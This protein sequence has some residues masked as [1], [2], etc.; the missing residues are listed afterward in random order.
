ME[1]E[2]PKFTLSTV[3]DNIAAHSMSAVLTE[4]QINPPLVFGPVIHHLTSLAAINTSNATV[5]SLI[6]GEFRDGLEASRSM[7]WVDVRDLS[8]AHVLALEKVA[9]AG[10]RFFVTAGHFSSEEIT[11]IIAAE[12]PE[13]QDRLPTGEGLERGALPPKGQRIEYNHSR[14]KEVLG[15]EYG[16][17]R[18]AVVDTV[19]S[20][21]AVQ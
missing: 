11:E 2:K 19:K 20:L 14:S 17:L 21:K 3:N 16:P 7:L 13:Y 12:F 8:R 4:R 6:K 18:K 9:A 10:Q 15:L 1:L 5:A